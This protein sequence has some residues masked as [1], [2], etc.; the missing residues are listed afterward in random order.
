M[1]VLAGCP[2]AMGA[3]CLAILSPMDQLMREVPKGLV[4]LKVYVDDFT[5]AHRVNGS[6]SIYVAAQKLYR[7]V[8]RLHELLATVKLKCSKDKNIFLTNRKEYA[9]VLENVLG[10]WDYTHEHAT[11]LLGVDYAGGAM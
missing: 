1:G 10:E 4:T 8:Q 9:H 3:L 6:N 2:V 11:R 7:I 5:I